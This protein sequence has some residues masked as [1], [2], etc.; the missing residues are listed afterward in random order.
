MD[1]RR[2]GCNQVGGTQTYPCKDKVEKLKKDILALEECLIAAV[3]P[4]TPPRPP[5]PCHCYCCCYC[6]CHQANANGN[7]TTW[8]R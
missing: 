5:R 7:Q 3:T 1:C 4:P 8:G 2:C 6:R